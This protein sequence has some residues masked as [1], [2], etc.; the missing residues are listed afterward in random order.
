MRNNLTRR[1]FWAACGVAAHGA[2]FGQHRLTS[3]G[4]R[5]QVFLE[6][7]PTWL[8]IAGQPAHVWTYNGL[9]PGPLIEL[10]PGDTLHLRLRNSLAEHT[11][12]H[13]HGLHVSPAGNGDNPFLMV[14]PGEEFDYEITIPASHPAGTFWYHPHVHGSSARQVFRG[15]SGAIVVRGDLDD[16][17]EVAA[18]EEHCLVLK[19]LAIDPAGGI[20]VGSMM[21]RMAG[22]EGSV[23]TVNGEVAPVYT[24]KRGALMRWRFVNASSS[25]Y[26][27]LSLEEHPFAVIA[28]DG[29][30]LS[31]T[32]LTGEALLTPGQR[33]DVL[34][35][36]DRTPGAY[37]LLN[38]P[39]DR[40]FGLEGTQQ[41]LA[42]LIYTAC[43]MM[44]FRCPA[45]SKRWNF[46]QTRHCRPGGS[47]CSR[48]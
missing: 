41:E 48:E 17:P 7:K 47:N 31:R 8:S 36:A 16:I 35:K 34:V 12:L 39:Y 30:S 45:D 32:E 40:G 10:R 22:R 42:R 2:A 9:M 13:F 25:R 6:A 20:P 5:L 28:V 11:N 38:L 14:P 43:R 29:G 24:V 18:A 19:D 4:G 1:D 37:R 44:R 27:R 21:E 15:L 46:C 23:L 26:Y 33:L 3:S